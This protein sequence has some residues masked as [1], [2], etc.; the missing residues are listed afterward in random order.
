MVIPHVQERVHAASSRPTS[1][2]RRKI[3]QCGGRLELVSCSHVGHVFRSS[4]HWAGNVLSVRA[5]SGHMP[6]PP[7]LTD[8]A[9]IPGHVLV[10]NRLR[11]AAVWMDAE[12]L[13]IVHAV[14]AQSDVPQHVDVGDVSDRRRVRER[15]QCRNFS[16][17]IDTVYPELREAFVP[18][19]RNQLWSGELVHRASGT[20]LD[21]MVRVQ[22]YM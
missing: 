18:L 13:E 10:R 8:G 19:P 20:C 14:I 22:A 4:E 12:Q 1:R 3:W 17:Y 9:Q 21:S 7:G 5:L 15:L 6:T 2:R 16:W 11:A